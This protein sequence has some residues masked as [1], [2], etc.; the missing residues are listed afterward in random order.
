MG[1]WLAAA[2]ARAAAL[3]HA[4]PRRRPA[5]ARRGRH[6]R[7]GGRRAPVTVE[8]RQG[9]ITR[10]TAADLAGAALVT[11]SALLDM[12]TAR[13]VERIVAACA[14]AGCPA[15]LTLS[16]SAGSSSPR[17]IRSTPRSRGVQRPPAPHRRRPAPARPGRG[18]RRGR[19]VRAGTAPRRA[20]RPSPWRL[21]PDQ[22]ELV[23]EWFAGWLAAA[24]RAATRNWPGRPP[25]YCHRRLADIAA[26]ARSRSSSTTRTC[27]P[28][29]MN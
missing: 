5:G 14:G 1:R 24:V 15:L 20:V 23:S 9:D 26:A 11:A 3:D 18:R 10:L 28:A 13:R 16:V 4:R 8:T 21:G 7:H 22:A 29:A 2:A 17:P 25:V 12:L 6:D 19:R 27:W